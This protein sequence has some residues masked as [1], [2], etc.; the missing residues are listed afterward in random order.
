MI[1]W[2][3]KIITTQKMWHIFWDT[4]WLAVFQ[5]LSISF[6]LV[7][8]VDSSM[9]P[10][11]TGGFHHVPG[12]LVQSFSTFGSF[13]E[14]GD[15]ED[16]LV[17]RL[18]ALERCQGDPKN[19]RIVFFVFVNYIC[20][21]F[22]VCSV[23]FKEDVSGKWVM[24][25]EMNVRTATRYPTCLFW[26]ASGREI[27]AN[28]CYQLTLLWSNISYSGSRLGEGRWEWIM[29][30]SR[31]IFE[32]WHS[33]LFEKNG[34]GGNSTPFC[35][36]WPRGGVLIKETLDWKML[37]ELLHSWSR[38]EKVGLRRQVCQVLGEANWDFALAFFMVFF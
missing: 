27:K 20:I 21:S 6:P 29:K 4:E 34:G 23:S 17:F 16:R 31:A 28:S 33:F 32:V 15:M 25:L 13:I 36:Q 8:V 35:F 5:D 7:F 2:H 14:G 1:P 18:K 37:V 24:R 22:K 12:A 30:V 26:I 10:T 3:Q 9:V 38:I 11:M 19:E